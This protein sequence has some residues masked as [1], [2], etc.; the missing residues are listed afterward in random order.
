MGIINGLKHLLTISA[1]LHIYNALILCHLNFG[2]LAWGHQCERIIKLKKKIVRITSLS[3]YNTHTKPIFKSV[4]LL[5]LTDIL[6]LQDL[7]IYYKYKN[8]KLPGIIIT[9][10]LSQILID[11]IT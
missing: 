10:L 1:K 7:K 5:K 3:K 4:K 11:F 6:K 9:F 8:N 2:I